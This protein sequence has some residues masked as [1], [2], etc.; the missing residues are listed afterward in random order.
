ML[1]T[2]TSGIISVLLIIDV[3]V[4]VHVKD[5]MNMNVQTGTGGNGDDDDED[6][7]GE[8]A[9]MEGSHEYIALFT[10]DMLPVHVIDTWYLCFRI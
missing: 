8:A 6:G 4:C 9:D 2:F 10:H 1:A 3:L 5:N 7:E